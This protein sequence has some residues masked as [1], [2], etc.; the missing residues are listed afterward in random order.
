ML[1]HG[2]PGVGKTCTAGQFL[3]SAD[4]LPLIVPIECV[5]EYS[6]RPLLPITR[7]DSGLTAPE[8]EKNLETH[9][10]LAQRWDCVL[11]LDEAD[12]FLARKGVTDI[13]RNALVSGMV[14]I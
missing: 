13:E 1:L 10:E 8:V 11:L 7:G 4:E 12:V 6:G 9:F 14:S 3:I 5:A 2:A